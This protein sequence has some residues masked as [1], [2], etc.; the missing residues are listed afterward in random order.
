LVDGFVGSA[1]VPTFV[2]KALATAALGETGRDMLCSAGALSP[3]G[4][5]VPMYI[6]VA[7]FHAAPWLELTLS[8][9]SGERR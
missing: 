6:L 1:A 7:H 8:R 5:M 9:R 3:L 4:G 2:L